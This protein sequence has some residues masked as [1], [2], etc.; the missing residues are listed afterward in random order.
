MSKAVNLGTLADDISVSNGSV[1]FTMMS[2]PHTHTDDVVVNTV[3]NGFLAGPI[4]ANNVTVQGHLTILNELNVTG[5]LNISGSL[6]FL[7]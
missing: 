5:D 3:N 7:G 2:N 1:S 6:K 4:T